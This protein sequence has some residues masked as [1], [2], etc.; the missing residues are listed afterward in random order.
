M[1]GR[2]ATGQRPTHRRRAGL[3]PL[4]VL[5]VTL[6]AAGC[7]GGGDALDGT[8]WTLTRS[9]ASAIDPASV[10][11]T[12]EF[13]DGQVT[14]SS[15][16]NTYGG[17]YSADDDGGFSVGTLRSTLMAGPE[18]AMAAESAFTDLLAQA[19][20]YDATDDQLTLADADGNEV[21]TF[22]AAS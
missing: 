12:A 4:L 17:E 16:V 13:A 15:G 9:S 2:R 10:T 11:I 20:A 6:A 1:T 14:G 5:A 18:P 19:T 3:V 21:L 8:S 22:T 7:S